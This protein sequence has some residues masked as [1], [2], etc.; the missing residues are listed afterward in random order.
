MNSDMR[1]L[2]KLILETLEDSV[3]SEIEELRGQ[4]E[5]KSITSFIEDRLESDVFEY[6]FMEMHALARNMTQAAIGKKYK[7]T[8]ASTASLDEVKRELN[9][10][11]FKFIGR[12]IPRK[13]RGFKSNPHGTHPFAGSGGGGSGFGSD[14][15]G[16][17][18]TSYGGG[19]G[20]VG[21]GY[22]WDPNDSRNLGMGA[23]KRR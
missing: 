20:A 18:F 22:A 4:P 21:G 15:S 9:D 3:E 6:N 19:P 14:R 2:K 17:T 23:K 8:A 11:G 1:L 16:T 7:I 13:T 10:M 12:Q 5:F